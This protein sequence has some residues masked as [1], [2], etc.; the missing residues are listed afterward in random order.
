MDMSV[1]KLEESAF[2]MYSRV[3]MLEFQ[4]CHVSGY[5]VC[6]VVDA[7]QILGRVMTGLEC[8]YGSPCYPGYQIYR[9]VG[10]ARCV[11]RVLP[12]ILI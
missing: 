1:A 4:D 2:T 8:W 3:A 12:I 11:S 10:E 9:P 7:G 5:G 6:R